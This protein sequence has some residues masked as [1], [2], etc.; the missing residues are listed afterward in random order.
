MPVPAVGTAEHDEEDGI[1]TRRARRWLIWSMIGVGILLLGGVAGGQG[2]L[3]PAGLSIPTELAVTTVEDEPDTKAQSAPAKDPTPA[4]ASAADAGARVEGEDLAADDVA[5]G[6]AATEA[7]TDVDGAPGAPT[8]VA[9]VEVDGPAAG[10][11][12]QPGPAEP[13]PGPAAPEP[14]AQPPP[15]GD[16]PAPTTTEAPPML[17]VTIPGQPLLEVD[18]IDPEEP[19]DLPTIV[20]IG[21]PIDLPPLLGR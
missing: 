3:P 8:P 13:S 11:P 5:A 9:G 14:P 17:S 18:E 15:G 4:T 20:I 2:I 6:P 16:T 19:L 7:E 1:L 21:I 10:G 12:T